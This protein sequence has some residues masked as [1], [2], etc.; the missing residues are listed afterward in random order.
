LAESLGKASGKGNKRET[1]KG[2]KRGEKSMNSS[3]T[4]E[5]IIKSNQGSRG[6]PRTRKKGA[7]RVV[8]K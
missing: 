6:P 2:K 3:G 8:S 5:R 7:K 4:L 1:T